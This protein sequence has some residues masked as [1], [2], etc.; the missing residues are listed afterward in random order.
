MLLASVIF[1]TNADNWIRDT[2]PAILE[3]FYTRTE[4]T[5]T[6]KRESL[7][8]MRKQCCALE[9]EYRSIV[10]FQD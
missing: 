3:V 7:F 8:S 10:Q 6:T 5:D 1:V 9:K 4:V 2:E